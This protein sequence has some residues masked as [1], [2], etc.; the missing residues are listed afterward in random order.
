MNIERSN[1][2]WNL[3][4][5]KGYL[6]EKGFVKSIEKLLIIIEK[7][8]EDVHLGRILNLLMEEHDV[9]LDHSQCKIYYYNNGIGGCLKARL[10]LFY[11]E[12]LRAFFVFDGWGSCEME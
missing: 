10:F 3:K 11:K 7:E 1:R 6:M 12:K 9:F 2:D 5:F 8:N 4:V